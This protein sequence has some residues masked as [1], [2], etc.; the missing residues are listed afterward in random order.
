MIGK[1]TFAGAS[2]LTA[3]RL[4]DI[5]DATVREA[6]LR[7]YG[8]LRYVDS[9]VEAGRREI[10]R[11]LELKGYFAAR[12]TLAEQAGAG[13]LVNIRIEIDEG[14]P[15]RIRQLEFVNPPVPVN[16]L[17]AV[18]ADR[19]G[20]PYVRNE[21]ALVAT[22]VEDFLKDHGYLDASVRGTARIDP[23]SG[24]AGITFA[25]EAGRSYEIGAIR[26]E[27][28]HA[29]RDAAVLSR[30]A[31]KSGAAYDAS[32]VDA[33]ARRLWFSGAFAEAEVKRL[34]NAGGTVDLLVQLEEA[35]ARRIQ[36]NLG[37]SQWERALAEIHYIDRNFLGSL[38]RFSI[39]GGISTR[40]YGIS[41]ALA[42]PWFLGTDATGSIGAFYSRRELPAYR[43]TETGAT[44]SLERSYDATTL[45]GY[46]VQYGWKRVSD[47]QIFGEEAG[48]PFDPDYTLGSIAF[49]QTY[50]TR[51]D[52]LSPMSGAYLHHEAEAA[53]PG[54]LGDLSFFRFDAQITYYVPL[55]TI[56]KERPFVP[57]IVLNHRAGLLLPYAGTDVVPVQERFF[58]GGPN[59]VR[60]YQ[61]DGLGPRDNNGVPLGGLA[62]L[63]ANIE[64]QWPVFNNVYLAAF[65]DA[66]NLSP[67]LAGL[68][69]GETQ[70]AAGP[71]LRVYTPIGAV[72]VDYGRNL[73]PAPGDPAG[74]WQFGF[75]FTF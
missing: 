56:S 45:T 51:N 41:S 12:A 21:E 17:N 72:R 37:Y 9:A 28:N 33:G 61:L 24:D 3:G 2:A 16:E 7:P 5:F 40:G 20:Q 50:D 53:T 27:G 31:V 6:T 8:R 34:P 23:P 54:L 74:N 68:D 22:R 59:T 26:V 18:V 48:R 38:N 55:R 46:R 66:G 43:A 1:V 67:T 42:N 36:F 4:L 35:P 11:A 49:A 32:V 25:V 57:F 69:L 75:G 44:L 29:T 13:N 73:N 65:T 39:D 14:I 30:F 60:S 63:L 10:V 52:I 47:S 19:L 64:L 70:F 15:Y 62:M 71:G 58:L